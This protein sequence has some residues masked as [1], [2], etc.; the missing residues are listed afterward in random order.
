VLAANTAALL[1]LL[2]LTP[3]SALASDRIGRR[4]LFLASAIG[5]VLA[6][7]PTFVM[8]SAGTFSRTLI[9]GLIFAG[10]NGFYS[11]CMGAAMVE[12]FPT[13]TRYT[14]IA[15]GYNL[16]QALLGGTASWVATSLIEWTGN[17]LA[18]AWYLTAA[19]AVAVPASLAIAN[20][21]REPLA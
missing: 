15:L 11:G 6:T 14:G 5:Y 20:R 3:F 12:L 21:H 7:Y 16:A 17:P 10:V 9:G 1:L 18:P 13:R 2:V 19:A 8:L 4:P